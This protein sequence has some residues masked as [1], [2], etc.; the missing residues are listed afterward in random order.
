MNFFNKLPAVIAV[1]SLASCI[2]NVNAEIV[3][4]Q[5]DDEVLRL[6]RD[7]DENTLVLFDCDNVL[8][9]L[10]YSV[11]TA[12]QAPDMDCLNDVLENEEEEKKESLKQTLTM[13]VGAFSLMSEKW[14]GL[15]D[16][17]KEKGTK[18]AVLTSYP[19]GKFGNFSIRFEDVR[20]C[21]LKAFGLEF[22]SFWPNVGKKEFQELEGL[23]VP[24]FDRQRHSDTPVFEDGIIFAG[25]VKKDDVLRTFFQHF[26]EYNFRKVIFIDDCLGHINGID[27]LCKNN[28]IPYLGICYRKIDSQDARRKRVFG[29]RKSKK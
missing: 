24:A 16:D 6:L 15:I 23:N 10:D 2:G 1:C 4:T 11:P 7:A 25:N 13:E 14:K 27:A 26:P 17:M 18:V 29:K 5:D 28:N 22:Q 19:V 3:I 8:I 21:E 12:N 9:S 20:K